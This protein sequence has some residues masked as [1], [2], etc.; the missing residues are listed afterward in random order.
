MA[1]EP[2]LFPL[3]AKK[4]SGATRTSTNFQKG[5][6]GLEV[7]SANWEDALR[8]F[9][10][11]PGIKTTADQQ[12]AETFFLACIGPVIG[13]LLRDVKD[14]TATH[15][16]TTLATG[17][18]QRGTTSAVDDTHKVF[19]L[20][21]DYS[22][23]TRSA[24]RIIT[25]PESGTVTLYDG[26]GTLISSGYTIDYTTGKVTFTSTRPVA[27][28]W[29]G[30]FY[31]PVH[32]Q[33][34]EIPWDIIKLNVASGKGHGDMPQVV[35]VEEREG[36]DIVAVL[37]VTAPTSAPT[38]SLSG[39]SA[40]VH[41]TTGATAGATY[42]EVWRKVNAGAYALLSTV[43]VATGGA[44]DYHDTALV[45]GDSNF[46]KVKA[47]NGG[48]TS[49][50]S[51]EVHANI[52]LNPVNPV[53]SAN[54]A[55]WIDGENGSHAEGDSIASITD[56][57]THGNNVTV[58]GAN[59]IFHK[60]GGT[61]HNH[62][63]FANTTPNGHFTFGTRI[64]TARHVILVFRHRGA[65]TSAD[66]G[67]G[68]LADAVSSTAHTPGPSDHH[69]NTE[70][71][72]RPAYP[73]GLS[74][75]NQIV[76]AG[77]TVRINGGTALPLLPQMDD[78]WA[79]GGGWYHPT[80]K[81]LA[82][83]K[84]TDF[85][86]IS[87]KTA[88][89]IA[90]DTLMSIYNIPGTGF[91]GD[92]AACGVWT[93]PLSGADESGIVAFLKNRYGL[94]T[95]PQ[96]DL[97][98]GDSLTYGAGTIGNNGVDNVPSLVEQYV[99]LNGLKS[100]AL[101][102]GYGSA[103]LLEATVD[104]SLYYM[105][106]NYWKALRD[107][108]R[109]RQVIVLWIG[110]NDI[111]QAGGRTGAQIYTNVQAFC[112]EARTDGF[113]VLVVSIAPSQFGGGA[114]YDLANYAT[115]RAAFNSAMDADHSFADGWLNYSSDP[116]IGTNTAH[117]DHPENFA[118]GIH[119]S[120]A[121]MA[122][123]A[124]LLGPKLLEVSTG[125]VPSLPADPHSLTATAISSSQ[126]DLAWTAGDANE[127]SFSI[128]RCA[129]ASCSGF[130][131]ITTV[132][133]GVTSFSDLGLNGS[134]LYRYRVRAHN[135]A[136]YSGYSNVA[137]DTT[138]AASFSDPSGLVGIRLW[139]EAHTE[140]YANNDPVPTWT[141]KSGG[142]HNL[143]QASSDKRGIFK[144][145]VLN[146]KSGILFDASS[147]STTFADNMTSDCGAFTAGR[148]VMMVLK[149]NA[150]VS[151]SMGGFTDVGDT[152]VVMLRGDANIWLRNKTGTQQF[153]AGS[154]Y[155][156]DVPH[157]FTAVWNASG[158]CSLYIDGT[159]AVTYNSGAATWGN[160]FTISEEGSFFS[161]YVFE[162]VVCAAA[163]SST[164]R[165]NLEVYE[166]AKYGITIP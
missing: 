151:S 26:T 152:A 153:G 77:A 19:Q 7:R 90:L 101:N 100:G 154:L 25:R 108:T 128:E 63:Y 112:N 45:D 102:L 59:A 48:G 91:D 141:D 66:T 57:S 110:Q 72:D 148:T 155:S 96:Q 137:Q 125:A 36:Q 65:R 33:D 89:N 105:Y 58:S 156:I 56:Q 34:D 92:L 52:L 126:M 85:L 32:F 107:P 159:L 132:S 37:D 23:G 93:S 46:Y 73:A 17:V 50:F 144:T 75:S 163:L 31:V 162:V 41:L 74:M 87:I 4:I 122:I 76:N 70:L 8:R 30:N 106:R 11:S 98:I 157:V 111:V 95:S 13:F 99:R 103:P 84:P 161:G 127:T 2:V 120:A 94:S 124:N 60:S 62:G 16:A 5:L 47:G 139:A 116:Q 28:T 86:I 136:G 150:L 40:D 160:G 54:L 1:V 15:T 18:T 10:I 81:T 133:A 88:G 140:A 145:G 104:G 134:T 49:G 83:E 51:N 118:D 147:G 123:L 114:V 113:K 39:S 21:K 44:L 79:T 53:G 146:G 14:Y 71:F 20:F 117:S 9:D 68:L 61:L 43:V 42:Y 80:L 165:H 38:L 115:Q 3:S 24:R 78:T 22:I 166:G 82:M 164:D 29:S 158:S 149:P 129:G 69:R 135:G 138:D 35:L 109:E 97:F 131:E 119:L 121:G 12:V 64:T 27:P 55:L 6:N 67:L 143:T 130:V 142:S